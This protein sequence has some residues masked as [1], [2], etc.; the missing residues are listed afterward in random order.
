MEEVKKK[1]EANTTQKQPP[2]TYS[3]A[4][5]TDNFKIGMYLYTY[6]TKNLKMYVPI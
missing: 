3:I 4:N 1:N 6:S 5:M 2:L